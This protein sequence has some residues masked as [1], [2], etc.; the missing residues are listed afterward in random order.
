MHGGLHML[1]SSECYEEPA[2][3]HVHGGLHILTSCECYEEMTQEHVHGD[4]HMLTS[5]AGYEEPAQ[6]HVHGGLPMLSHFIQRTGESGDL[7]SWNPSSLDS[8]KLL[9]VL[10]EWRSPLLVAAS[11]NFSWQLTQ[12]S[13]IWDEGP[14]RT[15]GEE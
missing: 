11:A 14:Y 9:P 2:Q 7:G 13:Q 5:H 8:K 6:E 1:T 4:L 12:H 10:T 3:E 15:L